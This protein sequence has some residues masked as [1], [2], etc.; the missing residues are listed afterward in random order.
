[1]LRAAAAISAALPPLLA[2]IFHAAFR[3]CA[4]I[5][6]ATLPRCCVDSDAGCRHAAAASDDA[7]DMIRCCCY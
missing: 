1:M 2:A 5:M 6:L 4:L 7:A 3:R